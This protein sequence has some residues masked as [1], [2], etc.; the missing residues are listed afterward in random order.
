MSTSIPEIEIA[1]SEALIPYQSHQLLTFID[2]H[3]AHFYTYW[4]IGNDL[5]CNFQ[6]L[7][8]SCVARIDLRHA[9]VYKT[10]LEKMNIVEIYFRS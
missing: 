6:G 10:N 8:E 7:L 1:K 3:F 4:S 2:C 9:M 5:L